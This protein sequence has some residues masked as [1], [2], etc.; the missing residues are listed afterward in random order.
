MLDLFTV[1]LIAFVILLGIQ[2]FALVRIKQMIVRLRTM[3]RIISPMLQRHNEIQNARKVN[4]RICQFCKYRQ[5]YIKTTSDADEEF[6]YRCRIK[7]REIDLTDSCTFF[8][9]ET[10]F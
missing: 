7:N 9:L 6:Y 2:I 5:A 4:M 8:E 1:L 10:E 3:L